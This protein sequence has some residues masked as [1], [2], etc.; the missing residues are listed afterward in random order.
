MIEFEIKEIHCSKAGPVACSYVKMNSIAN[1][2]LNFYLHFEATSPPT[3]PTRRLYFPLYF[4]SKTLI[5]FAA[6]VSRKCIHLGYHL[7]PQHKMYSHPIYILHTFNGRSVF[8]GC[9]MQ[10]IQRR[11]LFDSFVSA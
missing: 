4:T 1:I 2:F 11:E 6:V 5:F 10:S 9:I 8:R 7:L 3:P